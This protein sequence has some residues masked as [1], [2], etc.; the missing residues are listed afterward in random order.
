ME[1][2][3]VVAKAWDQIRALITPAVPLERAGEA[4]E[5]QPDEVKVVITLGEQ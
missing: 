2:T 5:L 4:F 3:S 1:P